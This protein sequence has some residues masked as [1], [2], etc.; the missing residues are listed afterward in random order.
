MRVLVLAASCLIRSHSVARFP[1]F[2]DFEWWRMW[3]G[4]RTATPR[5]CPLLAALRMIDGLLISLHLIQKGLTLE[6]PSGLPAV[7][8]G[9]L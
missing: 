5:W 2:A 9:G 6:P 3:R 4:I 8:S 1:R 7:P